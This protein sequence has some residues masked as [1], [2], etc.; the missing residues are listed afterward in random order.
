[1]AGTGERQQQAADGDGG[2]LTG[3]AALSQPGGSAG[4]VWT[5][6]PGCEWW[7]QQYRMLLYVMFVIMMCK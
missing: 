7:R 5:V 1:M 2:V 6:P 3:G 4:R